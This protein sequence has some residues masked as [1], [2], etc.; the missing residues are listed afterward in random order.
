MWEPV[1]NA[2][3]LKPELACGN[4]AGSRFWK[5]RIQNTDMPAAISRAA[6]LEETRYMHLKPELVFGDL[7]DYVDRWKGAVPQ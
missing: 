1:L 7:T 5:T 4:L 2:S 3:H 6:G